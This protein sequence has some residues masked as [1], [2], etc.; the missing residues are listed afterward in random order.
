MNK[1]FSRLTIGNLRRKLDSD[2]IAQ[3]LVKNGFNPQ[4]KRMHENDLRGLNGS[5]LGSPNAFNLTNNSSL[6]VATLCVVNN[7][8]ENFTFAL[9]DKL[10]KLEVPLIIGGCFAKGCD[11]ARLEPYLDAKTVVAGT[12]SSLTKVV[13]A[14]RLLGF[15]VPNWD[16]TLIDSKGYRLQVQ[17]GCRGKC[18]FCVINRAVGPPKSM[19]LTEIEEKQTRMDTGYGILGEDLGCWGM[20]IGK[21]LPSLLEVLDPNKVG[22]LGCI[23][24]DLFNKYFSAF[25]D[26]FARRTNRDIFGIESDI[27][28][29][30]SRILGLMDRFVDI[31]KWKE[32][33]LI[34]K[35][36]Y[37]N[38]FL[39]T[40]VMAGFPTETKEEWDMTVNLIQE[41]KAERY[42]TFKF[43]PRPGTL[44]LKMDG[45][46]NE[47]EK[48]SRCQQ[49]NT[50][51][52]KGMNSHRYIFCPLNS[53]LYRKWI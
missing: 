38:F 35:R 37:S 15:N 5:N 18:T 9:L 26:F 32:N 12:S 28:S 20:D 34:L 3:F 47:E 51:G 2:L 17:R 4:D 46:L 44:A 13:P 21:E 39:L 27:Q 36:R 25:E 45:Q 1:T 40:D 14:L 10:K 29:G 30:S 7:H 24:P 41:V 49:I 31:E 43:S 19:S 48:E 50:S 11:Q 53:H 42:R 22:F 8:R 33:I 16:D 6:I 23:T 52:Q